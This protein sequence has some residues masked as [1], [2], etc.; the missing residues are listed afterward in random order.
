V[1]FFD[2]SR[3]YFVS[4]LRSAVSVLKPSLLVPGPNALSLTS[5][6]FSLT[7]FQGGLFYL[8]D[9]SILL[10]SFCVSHRYTAVLINRGCGFL[11]R[12]AYSSCLFEFVKYGL[13]E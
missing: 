1:L 13:I 5:N 11:G 3:F 7:G 6:C 10:M 12:I 4:Y 8:G 9:I 2:D